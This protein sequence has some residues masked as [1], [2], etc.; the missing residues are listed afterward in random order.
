MTQTQKAPHPM[1][2]ELSEMPRI[3]APVSVASLNGRKARDILIEPDT[4]EC[5]ALARYLDLSALRKMRFHG[6][7]SPAGAQDWELS[8]SL[9][10]TVVQPCSVTLAP[11]TTRID[12]RVIRRFTPELP[13]PEGDEVEMT[14]DETL[15]PLGTQ[16]DLS[17]TVIEALALAAPDFPRAQGVAMNEDGVLRAAPDGETPLDDDAVKP[18]AGLKALRDKL[19]PS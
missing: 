15:E 6:T 14:I 18:F 11:V 7:L 13:E 16:I 8:G 1:T 3:A 4:A 19:D 5:A 2:S 10:A 9:G 12:E 17:A